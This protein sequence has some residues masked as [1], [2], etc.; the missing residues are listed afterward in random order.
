[1]CWKGERGAVVIP[2]TYPQVNDLIQKVQSMTGV[3]GD[4]ILIGKR[5]H[6]PQVTD[7]FYIYVYYDDQMKSIFRWQ[8][9][10]WVEVN[11]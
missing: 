2:E 3:K 7:G 4:E 11:N 8:G 6:P 5:E 1:M 10:Q 9:S